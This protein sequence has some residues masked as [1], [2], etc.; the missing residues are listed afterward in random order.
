M[1]PARC[2]VFPGPL[3]AYC[4]VPPFPAE[5]FLSRTVRVHRAAFC[6][7]LFDSYFTNQL[8]T[9]SSQR[10]ADGHALKP[11]KLRLSFGDRHIALPGNIAK[12]AAFRRKSIK[13]KNE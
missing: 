7:R 9:R 8:E 10:F 1:P 6:G 2:T 5:S 12:T 3:S 11:K 4:Q 13:V